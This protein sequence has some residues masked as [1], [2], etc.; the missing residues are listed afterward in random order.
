MV[1][2]GAIRDQ[3]VPPISPH[4]RDLRFSRRNKNCGEIQADISYEDSPAFNTK[5]FISK[6]GQSA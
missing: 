1:K 3:G 6:A 2:K 4:S 5:I